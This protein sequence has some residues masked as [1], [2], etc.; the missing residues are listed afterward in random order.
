[1]TNLRGKLKSSRDAPAE[2]RFGFRIENVVCLSDSVLAFHRNG[3]QG[4]SFVDNQ[5]QSV[6]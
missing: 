5:V 2:L 3:M 4:R 6:A 1:M